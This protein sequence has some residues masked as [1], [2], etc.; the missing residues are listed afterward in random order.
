MHPINPQGLP[1]K[2]KVGVV[3]TASPM[4]VGSD[5]A[6]GLI[7]LLG[8]SL[9]AL[10]LEV[11][12]VAEVVSDSGR[13]ARAAEQLRLSG[14]DVLCAAAATWSE[15]YLLTDIV[16]RLRVP[17]I[18]RSLPGM[19][20]G[21]LCGSIQFKNVLYELGWEGRVVYGSVDDPRA[22]EE[23]RVYARAVAL[24]HRLRHARIGLVGSHIKGMTEV[25]FDEFELKARLGPRLVFLGADELDRMVARTKTEEAEDVWHRLTPCTGSV[26][27]SAADGVLAAR[28]YAALKEF[29]NREG[30][31]GIAVECYPL[32]MGRV[33]L[34]FSLLS[35]EGIA[36]GCEGDVNSTVATLMLFLLTGEPVHNTDLLDFS[37]EEGT[38]VFSHCGSGA[39][40]LAPEPLQV[41]LSPV[42][43]ANRGVCVL[44]PAKSGKVTLLNLVGRR[45]T[46]RM[47][48]G[49]GEALETGM[50]FPGNPVK[51][52][53]PG[54]PRDFV[55][56]L[57]EYGLG[58][59]WM[60][61]YG[62]VRLELEE[63]ARLTG[64]GL[65]QLW[66]SGECLRKA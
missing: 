30:L 54:P 28:H 61:G 4:E 8:K 62:D 18:A 49:S 5:Q 40:S 29:I 64:M 59:H 57:A 2:P 56:R 50:A 39:F 55:G 48:V 16:E 26:T 63:V 46:Y 6:A 51:V 1:L 66:S 52:K 21:S 43:L 31:S 19:E 60:V 27:A 33:C 32:L 13:A 47:G 17:V 22:S 20:T 34:A 37:E 9:E 24:V 53:L 38:M 42:R 3:V 7:P 36:C 11:V 15:D 23:I 41:E 65:P 12:T 45:G 14:I 58:H 10:G 44:F 35:E 25:A